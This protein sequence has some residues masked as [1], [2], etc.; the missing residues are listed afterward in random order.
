MIYADFSC[1]LLLCNGAHVQLRLCFVAKYLV[2]L[3][4]LELDL[5][6]LSGELQGSGGSIPA[7]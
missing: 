2:Q 5:E 4:K 3:R 7:P 6:P 1:F